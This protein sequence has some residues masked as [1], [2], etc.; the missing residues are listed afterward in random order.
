M[1]DEG[2]ERAETCNDQSVISGHAELGRAGFEAARIQ[3]DAEFSPCVNDG[4][5]DA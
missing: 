2:A 3:R 4:R 5:R 1:L